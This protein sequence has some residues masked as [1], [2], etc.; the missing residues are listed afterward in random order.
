M[1]GRRPCARR[2]GAEGVRSARGGENPAHDRPPLFTPSVRVHARLVRAPPC[3]DRHASR[4]QWVLATVRPR[5]RESGTQSV[6]NFHRPRLTPLHTDSKQRP[7]RAGL[8]ARRLFRRHGLPRMGVRRPR[9]CLRGSVHCDGPRASRATI[10]TA[11]DLLLH[12]LCGRYD[13]TIAGRTIEY[14]PYR[15]RLPSGRRAATSIASGAQAR[16]SCCL[17]IR[18]ARSRARAS[19]ARAPALLPASAPLL[20][21]EPLAPGC[22]R[23]R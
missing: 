12:A 14:A 19:P 5:G 23:A 4:D 15:R 21:A 9:S 11:L 13:E 7:R 17:E 22:A 10:T 6:P 8:G 20:P 3:A 18:T 1:A 16:G 2:R